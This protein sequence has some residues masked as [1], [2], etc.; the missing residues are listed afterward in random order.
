MR[1]ELFKVHYADYNLKIKADY[2][3]V[4][5]FNSEQDLK[6]LP[7]PHK[8]LVYLL[9]ECLR[10][11]E[12]MFHIY[13]GQ[14]DSNGVKRPLS[15][16]KEK[17]M[18]PDKIVILY[19]EKDTDFSMDQLRYIESKLIAFAKTHPLLKDRNGQASTLTVSDDDEVTCDKRL[20]E[21]SKILYTLGFWFMEDWGL[22]EQ[23]IRSKYTLEDTLPTLEAPAELRETPLVVSKI[24]PLLEDSSSL[25]NTVLVAARED[26]FQRVVIQKNCWYEIR[27]H[28]R[29]LSQIKYIAFY[30][31]HPISAITHYAKVKEI[32]P[33]A[34]TGKYILYFEGNAIEIPPFTWKHAVQG[35]EYINLSEIVNVKTD[36]EQKTDF[37]FS[38]FPIFEYHFPSRKFTHRTGWIA[39]MKIVDVNQ[40]VL[41]KGS[42]VESNEE[43]RVKN[44]SHDFSL[45]TFLNS[46]KMYFNPLEHA[47]FINQ[48]KCYITKLDLTYFA[49]SSLI[50]IAKGA[51]N[52]GWTTWKT[53]DGETLDAVNARLG[54]PLKRPNI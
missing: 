21:L 9:L 2:I 3:T 45:C 39:R 5:V 38:Q 16:I 42:Y 43:Y 53:A 49:P 33:Y 6:T 40:F 8:R 27:I 22:D 12:K 35:S 30:R 17:E 52:N 25:K 1:K 29:K 41:L 28:P 34:D 46:K 23:T 50:D 37:D 18:N 48:K 19:T 32:K 13:V 20:A 51:A 36:S 10:N 11:E 26:G 44:N 54:N 15:S 4:E 7:L 24:V 14:T 31:T 47:D